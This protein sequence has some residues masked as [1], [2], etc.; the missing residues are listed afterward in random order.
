VLLDTR[1]HDKKKKNV[2]VS[3]VLTSRGNPEPDP[4]LWSISSWRVP[5]FAR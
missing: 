5:L 1:P 3:S 4:E 2:S